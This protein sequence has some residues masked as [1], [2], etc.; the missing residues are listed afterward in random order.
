MVSA[1]SVWDRSLER[2][3]FTA[4]PRCARVTKRPECLTYFAGPDLMQ[5]VKLTIRNL[6]GIMYIPIIFLISAVPSS[7]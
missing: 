6:T 5:L 4:R 2:S 1:S 7:E 3:N